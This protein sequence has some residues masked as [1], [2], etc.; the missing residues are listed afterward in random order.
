M[1]QVF[2]HKVHPYIGG[3]AEITICDV[4]AYIAIMPIHRAYL[5]QEDVKD[6]LPRV[7]RWANKVSENEDVAN[8]AT[9]LK[10]SL[11]QAK[12]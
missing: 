11:P 6:K 12:L 9:E 3:F 5:S 10:I 1:E 2:M 7:C 4:I 8:C